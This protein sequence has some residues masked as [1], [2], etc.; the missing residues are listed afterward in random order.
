MPRSQMSGEQIRDGSIQPVDLAECQ[1]GAWREF[2]LPAYFMRPK[3]TTAEFLEFHDGLYAHAF[4]GGDKDLNE[5][6]F[7]FTIPFDYKA[8]TTLHFR[9]HWAHNTPG[10]SG[11]RCDGPSIICA[12]ASM[13]LC[14]L[15]KRPRLASRRP[16]ARPSN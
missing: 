2:P 14:S 12:R 7:S 3:S 5:V 16:R 11:R 15:T 4:G 13:P 8:G 9:I 6:F 1:E 10:A